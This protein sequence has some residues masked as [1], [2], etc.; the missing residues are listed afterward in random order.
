M[1]KSYFWSSYF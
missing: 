1:N